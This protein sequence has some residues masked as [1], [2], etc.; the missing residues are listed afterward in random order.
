MNAV[1]IAGG[2]GIRLGKIT[3]E[4][5]KPM[6]KIG[7]LPIL[8]HQLKHLK[9]YNIKNVI[10][11]TGYLAEIIENY[12][13][14]NNFG[15]NVTCLKS[16]LELGNADRVKLAEKYLSNDFLVFYGDVMVDIDIERFIAFH[17]KKGGAA[18]L[19]IHPNDHPHDSDLVEIDENQRIIAFHP[20][21]KH[22]RYYQNLV[23]AGIYILSP[24]IFKY[25]G[26]QTGKELDFGKNIFPGLIKK[27]KIFG[28]N[29]PEY[30][31]D[32]GTPERLKQVEK[33]YASGKIA[34]RNLKNKQRAIFLDRDGTINDDPGSDLWDIN[35]FKIPTGSIKAVKL[36]NQS[37]Y[38]AIVITNQPVIAKGFASPED[39]EQIH[40]KMETLFGKD[41]AKLDAIYH[42]PHHPE[43]GYPEAN[44]KYVIQCGCRKPQPGMI[45]KAEKDS[46]I[47]LKNSYMI[48]DSLRDVLCGK[49]AGTKTILVGSEKKYRKKLHGKIDQKM[50]LPDHFAKSLYQAVKFIS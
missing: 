37:R 45:K 24:R 41:G 26:A 15:L 34:A 5:P 46:N 49:N 18:T 25:I 22:P 6:I 1:I 39:L 2:K 30:M 10:I 36:I 21:K 19:A 8:G 3:K 32:M 48:G 28:Y 40:R 27:E 23:N 14:K 43:R 33:D 38:L 29:T 31:K 12:V 7:N 42:C 35:K 17:K 50:R 47:D 9:E 16:N 11:L 44:V 4:T 13:Q 20:K